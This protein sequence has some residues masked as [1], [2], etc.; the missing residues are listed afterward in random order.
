MRLA[1]RVRALQ[2]FVHDLLDLEHVQLKVKVSVYHR[3]GQGLS[4]IM[5]LQTPPVVYR[6]VFIGD[7]SVGKTCIINRLMND[8]FNSDEQTT[9]GAM[10][11]MYSEEV[12]S[13]IIEMQIWDTAGQE[14]FRSLGPVYY[15]QAQI[16]IIVLDLSSKTTLDHLDEWIDTFIK[17]AGQDALLV[18]AANKLDLTDHIQISDETLE[19][20]SMSNDIKYFKVSA[21]EGIGI[22]EMFHYLARYLYDQKHKL[23]IEATPVQQA[24]ILDKTDKKGCSC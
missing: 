21:K 23:D 13:D 22:Q 24:A 17:N 19:S 11:A 4:R 8:K 15:R 9:V 3:L 5:F 6:V 7:S 10:F 12:E 16:G 2:N 14:K 20:V 18:I 1:R